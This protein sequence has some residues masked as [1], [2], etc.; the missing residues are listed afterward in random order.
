MKRIAVMLVVTAT[1][2]AAH[3]EIVM[4]TS[5]LPLLGGIATIAAAGLLGWKGRRRK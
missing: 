2:A 4:V 3:H 1:P 5:M